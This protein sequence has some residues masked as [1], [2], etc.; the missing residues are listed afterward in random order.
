[1]VLICMITGCTAHPF[2]E[3]PSLTTSSPKFLSLS[4][5]Y[6]RV[7]PIIAAE[8]TKERQMRVERFPKKVQKALT[9]H[10]VAE[11][12]EMKKTVR[13]TNTPPKVPFPNYWND[14]PATV[15]AG[16]TVVLTFDDGPSPS[17]KA[18]INILKSRNIPAVFFWNTYHIHFVTNDIIK[19]LRDA[20]IL[21]GDHTV[22][23]PNL[24]RLN[25]AAQRSEIVNGRQ[26]IEKT[27]GEPVLFFRPPYGNYNED[28]VKILNEE[29]LQCVLWDVDS[30]DWKY[31]NNRQVIMQKIKAQLKPGAIILMHD[32]SSTV[33]ILPQIIDMI[34]QEGYR[35]T[36]FK[37]SNNVI[38]QS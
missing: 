22:D 25:Y 18:L 7:S 30:E 12:P 15:N 5:S 6:Q 35:F 19:D 9:D 32:R 2:Y 4:S 13:K 8:R 3:N 37:T 17:T 38:R 36:T 16:K 20:S 34:N 27:L 11:H 21:V 26:V 31:P 33:N 29:K 10:Q 14:K 24:N 1:M 23:H 28:T